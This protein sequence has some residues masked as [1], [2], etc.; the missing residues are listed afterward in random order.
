MKDDV[1]AY[2]YGNQEL[3]IATPKVSANLVKHFKKK[4]ISKVDTLPT[5]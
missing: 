4:K 3:D 5:E 2:R 1:M